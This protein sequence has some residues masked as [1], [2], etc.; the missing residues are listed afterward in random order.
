MWSR[1]TSVAELGADGA[2]CASPFPPSAPETRRRASRPSTSRTKRSRSVVSAVERA[3]RG[4]RARRR[5]DGRRHDDRRRLRG[6]VA[7]VLAVTGAACVAPGLGDG[8]CRLGSAPASRAPSRACRPSVGVDCRGCR[9]AV[10]EPASAVAEAAVVTIGVPAMTAAAACAASFVAVPGV[11]AWQPRSCSGRR[12]GRDR[13]RRCAV[14][15]RSCRRSRVGVADVSGGR[16]ASR[17]DRR[18]AVPAASRPPA[19]PSVRHG[20]NDWSRPRPS[21]CRRGRRP[22]PP[23]ARARPGRPLPLRRRSPPLSQLPTAPGAAGAARRCAGRRALAGA[24]VGCDGRRDRGRDDP[25]EQCGE[26][27]RDARGRRVLPTLLLSRTP[28]TSRPGVGALLSMGAVSMIVHLLSSCRGHASGDPA[29][30]GELPGVVGVVEARDLHDVAGVRRLEEL[31]VHRGRCPRGGCSRWSP[32][33]RRCRPAAAM[34][35]RR[36]GR[37]CTGRRRRAGSETP[38]CP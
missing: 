23:R 25:G 14:D 37:R 38:D 9:R 32:G 2:S 33:R 35:G 29:S 20:R 18:T 11:P 36:A 15:G 4:D 13:V 31:V 24:A 28:R 5:R 3:H 30:A 17:P 19:A 8:R 12:G 34:R 16:R 6:A 21:R 1:T 27:L 7:I 26:R 10:V 22:E